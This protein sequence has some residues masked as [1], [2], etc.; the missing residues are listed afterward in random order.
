MSETWGA[1]NQHYAN[2]VPDNALRSAKADYW[3]QLAKKLV[4]DADKQVMRSVKTWNKVVRDQLRDEMGFRLSSG[5]R[6]VTVPVVV[7]DGIPKPMLDELGNP[8]DV[9]A[10]L[11]IRQ[12]LFQGTGRGVASTQ[13]LLSQITHALRGEAPTPG[14]MVSLL[15]VDDL[16]EKLN[17]A[18][19]EKQLLERILKLN[20]DILGAYYFQ[21]PKVR[22]F[23]LPIAIVSVSAGTPIEALTFV[24]LAHELAHAYT[25]LGFDIDGEAWD[26]TGFSSCELK[27]VEGLAQYYTEVVCKNL[28][29]RLPAAIDCFNQMLGKQNEIYTEYKTWE[30]AESG[31][32]MRAYLRE[33]SKRTRQKEVAIASP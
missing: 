25:H 3:A 13:K 26:T 28:A 19:N 20:Q 6:Q 22:V 12:R 21:I 31:E 32:S 5:N 15:V 10:E 1:S 16:L 18:L 30:E 11:L 24:V 29:G 7:T 14:E 9:W 27:V 23:W 33:V 17:K 4:P 8:D 2:D